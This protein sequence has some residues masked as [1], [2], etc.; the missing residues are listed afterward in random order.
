ML[1]FVKRKICDVRH[2]FFRGVLAIFHTFAL[3]IY[4]ERLAL[5][6]NFDCR[7]LTVRGPYL[8]KFYGE[9]LLTLKIIQ[10]HF[11]L[12]IHGYNALL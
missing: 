11:P 12:T 5:I 9:Q 4:I 3:S 10:S 7:F 6:K 8:V 2:L 1:F